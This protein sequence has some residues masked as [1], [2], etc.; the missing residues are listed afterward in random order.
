MQSFTLA[1]FALVAVLALALPGARASAHGS[2]HHVQ[3]DTNAARFARGMPPLPP[4]R[5][6]TA[7]RTSTTQA[8]V[9]TTGRI[10]LRDIETSVTIGYLQ[11]SV[12]GPTGINLGLDVLHV[13]DLQVQFDVVQKSLFCLGS[14][15]EGPG[16]YL[17]AAVSTEIWQLG[18]VLSVD[19]A[20]VDIN[21]ET[22]EANL[23]SLDLT[24]GRLS[25]LWENVDL[26][27][28]DIHIMYDK[29]QNVVS[30]CP[31]ANAYKAVHENVVEVEWFLV[32]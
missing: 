7:K 24:T 11:N 25:G 17:G 8:S 30:F 23:W 14:L 20:A 13:W 29:V 18:Q 15:F 32:N 10:Q 21:V 22:F 12:A 19:L 4:T 27:T 2:G 5:R 1:I 26:T 6:S 9:P 16:Y 31:D 28:I 3:R